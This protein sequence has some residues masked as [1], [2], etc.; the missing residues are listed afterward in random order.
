[1]NCFFCKGSMK[2]STTTTRFVDLKKCMI[3]VKNVPFWECEHCGEILLYD[4]VVA[5]LDSI[6]KKVSELVTEIAVVEYDAAA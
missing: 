4:E 2:P 3:I 1:M 6:I 5:G